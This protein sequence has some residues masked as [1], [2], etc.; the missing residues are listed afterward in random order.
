[1]CDGKQS[2]YQEEYQS[3]ASKKQQLSDDYCSQSAPP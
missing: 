3:F 2:E 1:M